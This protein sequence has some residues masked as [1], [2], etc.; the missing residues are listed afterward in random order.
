MR[1]FK[2]TF[3]GAFF[4]Y[5]IVG[6]DFTT[7]HNQKQEKNYKNFFFFLAC[8]TSR[9][10]YTN[11]SREDNGTEHS[12]LIMTYTFSTVRYLELA[13]VNFGK[14]AKVNKII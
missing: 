14:L 3:L 7:T 1:Y 4:R 11:L 9:K 10:C 2:G 5:A 13:V 6:G 8:G 12:P